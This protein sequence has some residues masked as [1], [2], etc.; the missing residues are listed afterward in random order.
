MFPWTAISF[1]L[2]GCPRGRWIRQ[3]GILKPSAAQ[4]YIFTKVDESRRCGAML[5]QIL[6][7]PLPVSYVTTGQS[8]PEDI[9]K[10]E[11]GKLLNL[12]LNGN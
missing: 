5:N 8:V 2:W 12:I 3:P 6:R 1:S 4:S 10:A 9:E 11:K 7:L